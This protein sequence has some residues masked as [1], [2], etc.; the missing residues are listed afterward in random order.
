MPELCTDPATDKQPFT[1]QERC[2]TG[3]WKWH[4]GKVGLGGS[5]TD[6]GLTDEELECESN[7]QKKG[8]KDG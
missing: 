1:S 2:W 3:S 8:R 7:G 4:V 5:W 6:D